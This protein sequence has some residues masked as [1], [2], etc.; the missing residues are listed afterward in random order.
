MSSVA[1]LFRKNL[2]RILAYIL[3]I[4]TLLHSAWQRQQEVMLWPKLR[5]ELGPA[6]TD[7]WVRLLQVRQWLAGSDFFDHTLHNTNAPFD[8]MAMHWTRPMDA[9]ISLFHAFTPAQWV[10]EIRLMV[11]AAWLP[12]ALGIAAFALLAKGALARFNNIHV[13]FTL[14]FLLAVNP[15][16]S[17]FT[18][19]D[20]DHHSIIIL[21]WCGVLMLLAKPFSEKGAG[22]AGVMLGVMLWVGL[23]SLAPVA[24]IYAVTGYSALLRPGQ[25]RPFAIMCVTTALTAAAGLMVEVPIARYFTHVVYDTLSIPYV[26]ALAFIAA[27]AWLV[28]CER[29]RSQPFNYRLAAGVVAGIVAAGLVLFLFPKIAQGPLADAD[30]FITQEFFP[31]VTEAKPLLNLGWTMILQHI[32][33]PLLALALLLRLQRDPLLGS[34]L[35]ASCCLMLY[36]G[37]FTYYAQ[38]PAMLAIATLLPAYAMRC[39]RGL[40]KV[41]RPYAMLLACCGVVMAVGLPFDANADRDAWACQ[42]QMRYVIQTQQ[43]QKLAGDKPRIIY[44]P[45]EVGGDILFFT[46][47]RIIAG[48]YHREGKAMREMKAIATSTDSAK[49]RNLLAARKVDSLLYCPIQAPKDS[50]LGKKPPL[51]LSPVKGLSFKEQPGPKPV[52]Y[53]VK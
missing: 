28:S 48:E 40:D 47:Y 17:Y 50:W 10:E 26:A 52:F 27:G 46:P 1:T 2:W 13:L 12:A 18:P 38:A 34:V 35:A 51:W 37:R 39:V 7:I 4:I 41:L 21:M 9:L 25:L 44:A 20:I 22:V 11:A 53:T 49:A 23:E 43:L 8:G 24:I 14:V 31:T 30:P 3:P 36:Q 15:L 32:W 19:G 42:S 6:D 45:A 5:A 16:A 29:I 33:Q